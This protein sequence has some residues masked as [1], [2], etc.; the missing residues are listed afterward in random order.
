MVSWENFTN[1]HLIQSY[2]FKDAFS[3][4]AKIHPFFLNY[5]H[6]LNFHD[7][8]PS[9][10]TNNLIIAHHVCLSSQLQSYCRDKLVISSRSF[11]LISIP[12]NTHHPSPPRTHQITLH[13]LQAWFTMARSL[14]F[15]ASLLLFVVSMSSITATRAQLD[16]LG[17][18]KPIK[19]I[20]DPYIQ[21]IGEFAVNE[22]NK[23]AKTELKFQKVISGKFQIVAGTNY[24][25]RLTALEGTVSRTY[26]TLVFTDL[27]KENHLILFYG[28]TN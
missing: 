26:G 1:W 19:D 27:K 13:Q 24:H 21:S 22:H 4:T 9:W 25:L 23:Q 5:L 3:N 6:Q 28:I 11:A 18:Y 20:A 16:L 2:L 14:F 15:M 8:L 17:G 10:H 7:L 12:I